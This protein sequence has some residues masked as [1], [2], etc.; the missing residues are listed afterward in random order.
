MPV[1]MV[2]GKQLMIKKAVHGFLTAHFDCIIQPYEFS[3]P[4]FLWLIAISLDDG[5]QLYNERVLYN[6][7]HNNEFSKEQI[8]VLCFIESKCLR[9]TLSKLVIEHYYK[10]M[11]K[12]I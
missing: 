11:I 2:Q 5:G 12:C 10:F 6:Y 3:L 7:K 8:D 4:E 1:L 9:S